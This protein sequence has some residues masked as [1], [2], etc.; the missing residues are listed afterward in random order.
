MTVRRKGK[1]RGRQG[2]GAR[3]SLT[4]P[5]DN[6]TTYT[7]RLACGELVNWARREAFGTARRGWKAAPERP[8]VGKVPLR[9]SPWARR[10]PTPRRS[11]VPRDRPRAK[12]L[13]W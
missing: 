9:T 1:S 4:Q 10:R 5:I 12:A 6:R 2:P 3:N 13:R 7:D 11:E 8:T